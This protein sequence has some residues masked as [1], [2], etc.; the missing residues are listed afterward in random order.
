MNSNFKKNIIFQKYE[1]TRIKRE[2]KNH[3]KSKVIWFTGLS[4]SGK[5][6]IS[7][8]LE[9][10]LFKNNINTY[11]L[12]GDNIRSGL[13]SDLTFCA[14]DRDE[15]IRRISEVAKLM[16]DAG[17]MVLVSVISPY[18]KQRLMASNILGKNN[19]LEVFVDTPLN[20]C[21]KRDSKGLYKKS[22]CN[23]IS[24]FTGVDSLYEAPETP[25]IHLDGTIS[26]KENIKKLIKKLYE[27]NVIFFSTYS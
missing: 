26:I 3:Y 5:S 25:D 8:I 18:K 4:G 16:L 12:D 15:N 20:I 21:E 24:D 17:I 11:V 9:K 22:R 27:N 1:V 13:C 6:T 7:N 19:F 2:N 23:E 10:I 14:V